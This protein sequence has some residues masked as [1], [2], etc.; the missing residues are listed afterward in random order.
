MGVALEYI[1][2]SVDILKVIKA[3]PTGLT[4]YKDFPLYSKLVS[5]IVR[6]LRA[7]CRHSTHTSSSALW[8]L[9]KRLSDL[10]NI[11]NILVDEANDLVV[12]IDWGESLTIYK[13]D[14]SDRAECEQKQLI[15][16]F[17]RSSEH[18]QQM[19]QIPIPGLQGLLHS[20]YP[21]IFPLPVRTT[22]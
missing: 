6:C 9:L 4:K 8:R 2:G 10:Q 18:R 19:F 15:R 16:T 20:M 22:V 7:T 21:D 14:R 13:E 17:L 1:N 3:V 12:L 5:E 11:S